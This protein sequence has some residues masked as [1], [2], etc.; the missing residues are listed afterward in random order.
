MYSER[1]PTLRPGEI[2]AVDVRFSFVL[3]S[4]VEGLLRLRPQKNG[5]SGGSSY[6]VCFPI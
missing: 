2:Q 4:G 6:E 5:L 1:I 3:A